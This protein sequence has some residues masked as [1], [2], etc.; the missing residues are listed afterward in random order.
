MGALH[1]TSAARPARPHAT[2]ASVQTAGGRRRAAR[3]V[4]PDTW[5]CKQVPSSRDDREL[6]LPR[7]PTAP[8]AL[9]GTQGSRPT[10][11]T[12]RP[13]ELRLRAHTHLALRGSSLLRP[14]RRSPSARRRLPLPRAGTPSQLWEGGGGF[15]Q[16]GSAPGTKST[17]PAR[18]GMS[19]FFP[20]WRQPRWQCFHTGRRNSPER[21]PQPPAD[22]RRVPALVGHY[23][24]PPARS[25]LGLRASRLAAHR[26]G[27]GEEESGRWPG[28]KS[29]TRPASFVTSC[30]SDNPFHSARA[31]Y[32]F[33]WPASR[34]SAQRRGVRWGCSAL[35]VRGLRGRL[36]KAVWGS[37]WAGLGIPTLVGSREPA[38]PR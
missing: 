35:D 5:V 4:T 26:R 12:R 36:G 20:L 7:T 9:T 29:E 23:P 3:G 18:Q 11:S 16:G 31:A 38:S 32:W 37:T 25:G 13:P 19:R 17:I 28:R 8:S 15:R 22:P 21:G 6:T 1:P 30:G 34:D 27:G 2:T 14:G 24:A 33:H 10:A